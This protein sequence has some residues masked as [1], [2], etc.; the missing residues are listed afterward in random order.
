[1]IKWINRIISV[2]VLSISGLSL[3]HSESNTQVPKQIQ[4]EQMISNE[5]P[6]VAQTIDNQ[7]LL[8]FYLMFI[9]EGSK[10]MSLKMLIPGI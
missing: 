9:L 4:P 8:Q 10:V 1:M 5:E 3:A 2:V 7:L 6:Q